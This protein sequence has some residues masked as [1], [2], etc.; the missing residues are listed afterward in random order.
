MEDH[1]PRRRMIREFAIY[2]SEKWVMD[3][4]TKSVPFVKRTTFSPATVHPSPLLL[5]PFSSRRIVLLPAP[6]APR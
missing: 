4:R 3:E 5:E 6:N 1:D 2:A